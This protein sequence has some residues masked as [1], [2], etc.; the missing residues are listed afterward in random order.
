MKEFFKCRELKRSLR[1]ESYAQAKSLVKNYIAESERIFT[2]IRSGVLTEEMIQKIVSHYK[3]MWITRYDKWRDNEIIFSDPAEQ[4]RSEKENR[5]FNAIIR[6]DEEYESMLS[7]YD[8]DIK[9]DRTKL[10]RRKGHEDQ[11]IVECIDVVLEKLELQV[12]KDSNEYKTLCNKLL[13][14]RIEAGTVI[15]EHLAG[16]YDT[17]YDIQQKSKKNVLTFKQLIDLYEK[18][19]GAKWADSSRIKAAHRQLFHIIGNK[20]LDEIDKFVTVQLVEALQQY[21]KKINQK[22]MERPWKEL[23]AIKPDR[24][25][26]S[27]Q[28]FIKTA[29]ATIIKYAKEND[30]GIKGNPAK[31]IAEKK[32]VNK[33]AHKPHTPEELQRLICALNEVDR[34]NEPEMFWIPLLLL[35]TGARSN[36]ICM[37]R[38]EDIEKKEDIWIF[39]FRNRP[40]YYQRTKNHE[41]RQ[42]PIHNHIIQ[43]G[44]IDYLTNQHN[45]GIERLFQN[46]KFYRDK[47]NVYFGK[48]YNRTF[49]KKFLFGYTEEELKVKDLHSFRKNMISWYTQKSEYCNMMDISILQSIIGHFENFE[50]SKLIEFLGAS[51]LTTDVYGGGYGQTSRQNALLQNLDYG[52]DLSILTR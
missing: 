36:E 22:E 32:P 34:K 49:K 45:A 50:I 52:L 10:G 35:Y 6:K 39:N 37:L 51:K 17:D 14:A 25:S 43:L 44:F 4:N 16:N 9:E 3:N 13:Q 20:R 19:Q 2:M 1:T 33:N 12:D 7:L 48:D 47:W 23:S 42:T 18:D 40:E 30:L 28:H 8:Q 38:C 46:L 11:N 15:R 31:G 29:F 24:L 27:S 21:P 5:L 26:E 41:D